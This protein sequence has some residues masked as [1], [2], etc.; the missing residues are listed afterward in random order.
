[1]RDLAP[2][3]LDRE[4][5]QRRVQHLPAVLVL[6]PLQEPEYQEERGKPRFLFC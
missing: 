4:Q 2:I 6:G 1:M 3:E 5:Q